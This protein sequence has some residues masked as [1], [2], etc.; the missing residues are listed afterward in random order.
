MRTGMENQV[1]MLRET[2]VKIG[3]KRSGDHSK[4]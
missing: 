2:L 4:P 3:H 1:K